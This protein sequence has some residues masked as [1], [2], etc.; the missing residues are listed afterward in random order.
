MKWK[1]AIL[2]YNH[3]LN[4]ERGLSENTIDNYIR[5]VKKFVAFLEKKEVYSSPIQI[6]EEF[7][8][9]FVYDISKKISPRSQARIISGLRS[10]FEYLIFENYRESNPTDLIEAPKT[11]R[12]LPDTLSE[13][14]I[15]S[16]ITAIDLSKTEGERNRAML[17]TMY[18]CGLRVSELIHLKISDLFFDE[19][20]IKIIGKG[21]KERFVPIHFRA[22]KYII[23]Y[24][25]EI[26]VHLLVVKGFED[27]LFLN[28]RGKSLSRQMVFMILKELAIKINLQKKISPHTF[29][30]S[31]ATHLLKNGADL[32]AIQ[33]MLG[34]ES[35][36][37]T[38]VYVHLDTSFLK[39]V[40]EK[41]HPRRT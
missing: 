26:R 7:I 4:I 25:N 33:Q 13:E 30:H 22:Q 10:F 21:N 15:N 5:D 20:F 3:Y 18:S 40:V 8:Q 35:I 11:G 27:T 19:G 17:E 29:R 28:R 23:L 39:K 6:T 16:L 41:Y 38:E 2:D 12:K 37:T 1:Q 31:F 14:E 34:H 9:E 24:M 32:R 36:T